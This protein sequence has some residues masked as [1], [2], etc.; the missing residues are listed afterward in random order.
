M[1]NLSKIN[2]CIQSK[3]HFKCS[4]LK[5]S[6]MKRRASSLLEGAGI[7]EGGLKMNI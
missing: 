3:N 7:K 6:S 4:A 1:K 2:I 5:I